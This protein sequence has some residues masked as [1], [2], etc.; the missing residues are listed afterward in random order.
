MGGRWSFGPFKLRRQT[1][2]ALFVTKPTVSW[3][4]RHDL[5]RV[6]LK[7]NATLAFGV[8]FLL[9]AELCFNGCSISWSAVQPDANRGAFHFSLSSEA[10]C[11]LLYNRVIAR[12]ALMK[13]HSYSVRLY[14]NWF[15][16]P[17]FVDIMCS[18]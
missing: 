1:P 3:E 12:I 11:V 14:K 2:A 6:L 4:T 8:S 18:V 5:T 17:Y 9:M 15:K 16:I 10:A 7:N 13:C